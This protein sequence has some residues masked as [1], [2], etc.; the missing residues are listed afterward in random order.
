MSVSPTPSQPTEP[1]ADL[2]GQTLGRYRIEK[3][4]G[5]GGMAWVYRARDQELERDVAIKVITPQALEM[6]QSMERFHREA[7]AIARLDHPHIVHLY[8]F[9]EVKGQP[10][11][12]MQYIA[13]PSLED[14]L[15]KGS[16][17]GRL[18]SQA[19]V[20]TILRQVATALD[21]AHEQGLVHRDVKPSNVLFK[22]PGH[23][24]LTDFGV[25]RL[26]AG[27]SGQYSTLTGAD[28]VL[29]T[30][31]YMAPEQ[32]TRTIPTSPATDTYSLAVVAYEMLSGQPPF[33][34][35]STL[36]AILQHILEPPPSI[37]ER[38]PDL[39]P[40]VDEVLQRALDKDPVQRFP[41]AMA[42]VGALETAWGR[43][44]PAA[45]PA[46]APKP[47]A[48]PVAP[49]ARPAPMPVP[50]APVARR[51]SEAVPA[52]KRSAA[53]GGVGVGVV[54]IGGGVAALLAIG[55]LIAGLWWIGGSGLLNP[56]AAATPSVTLQTPAAS[57]APTSPPLATATPAVTAPGG[58]TYHAVYV[59][60]R[61]TGGTF[62]RGRVTDRDERPVAGVFVELY[63]P[64]RQW[65]KTVGTG[66]D[67]RYEFIV[68]PNDYYLRLKNQ[69]GEWS[70]RITVK[71]SHE[72]IV[73]W[74]EGE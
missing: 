55:L 30:P 65:L 16:E 42:F 54:L 8:D 23:A 43:D 22:E 24:V 59:G 51:T 7:R 63:N 70:P 26:H 68:S 72:A 12:V 17:R 40:A 11:M 37:C 4:L 35:D 18:L 57:P 9:G 56:G 61:E 50:P 13:G 2:I 46:P 3:L 21:Y 67:G 31:T 71:F 29:G 34:A 69:P 66:A 1:G 25:A 73:N 14:R 47:A 52:R 41:T 20:L 27:V 44:L 15:R 36:S 28:Q 64:E 53:W 58:L 62:I 39:P 19:E 45:E 6:T 60:S 74:A 33:E 10:Y 38:R 48:Q 32:A 5:C 49:P